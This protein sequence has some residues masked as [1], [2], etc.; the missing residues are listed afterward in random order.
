MFRLFFLDRLG[1]EPD[2]ID[3]LEGERTIFLS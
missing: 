1:D 3:L 2:C